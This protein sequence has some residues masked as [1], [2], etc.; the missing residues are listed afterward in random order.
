MTG[1]DRSGGM[2]GDDRSGGS[3]VRSEGATR[4]Y[5]RAPTLV[6]ALDDVTTAFRAG[7]FSAIMGPSGSGKST[8]LHC[9]A[10]LD[11]LTA[12][13]VYIGETALSTLDD[14]ALTR[15][16]RCHVGLIF[17]SFNLL[18]TLTVTENIGLPMALAGRRPDADWVT[19]LVDLL[20]I[21]D[22]L[23]HRP[24]ELSGGEQQ[25]VAAAR[26]LAARPTIVFADEPTG[27]LDTAAGEELLDLLGAVVSD[28]GQSV[29]MV[30]HDPR[31]ACHAERVVFLVDGR[32]AGELAP[33]TP[34]AVLEH[35]ELV[36]DPE[37]R[38]TRTARGR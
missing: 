22:R 28:T 11:R 7:A 18:P 37:H 31:A 5:G 20:G 3:A 15:L 8:L 30:T 14:A 26:A 33:P 4:H 13:E 29:V 27:N 19:H 16:R 9:L 38:D 34:Q 2:T 23:Q 12:G 17:Q 24:S 25:R 36:D 32:V 21:G 10:G 1:D 6:R 35:L